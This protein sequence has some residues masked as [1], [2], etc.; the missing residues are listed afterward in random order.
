MSYA[1]F[2]GLVLGSQKQDD[3][4]VLSEKNGNNLDLPVWVPNGGIFGLI[5]TPTGRCWKA[6]VLEMMQYILCLY[7]KLKLF[8]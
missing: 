2:G 8:S 4:F 6:F 3:P 1:R 5:G 7:V